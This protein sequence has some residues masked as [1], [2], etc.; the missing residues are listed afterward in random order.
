MAYYIY[1]VSSLPMLHFGMK[2]P[3]SFEKFLWICEDLIPESELDALRAASIVE[4]CV[5]DENCP[6][7]KKWH[8]F[9]KLLRNELVKVRASRRRLDPLKHLRGDGYADPSVAHTALHAHRTPSPLEAEKIL[10][11]ARWRFLEELSIGH[12]FDIDFLIVYAVK[13]LIL[14]RWEK[15]NKLDKARAV[16]DVVGTVFGS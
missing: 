11:E 5:H 4:Q 14:E 8:D 3:L 10:D 12:Y 2:P 15:I 7:L 13:L 9:D 16:A 1:L 6:A